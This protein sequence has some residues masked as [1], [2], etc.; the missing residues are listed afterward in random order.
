MCIRDR[1]PFF[2]T[3]RLERVQNIDRERHAVLHSPSTAEVEVIV[4]R[5]KRCGSELWVGVQWVSLRLG[6]LRHG[7]PVGVESDWSSG[8]THGQVPYVPGNS[9]N[10]TADV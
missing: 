1:V 6:A 8:P 2:E 10:E 3:Q 5:Q 7:V 9:E 4:G